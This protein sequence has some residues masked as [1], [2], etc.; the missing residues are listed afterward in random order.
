MS[1]NASQDEIKAAFRKLARQYH[2][3]INKDPGATDKFKEINEAY[4]VLGDPKKRQQFDTYG[5]VGNDLGGFNMNEINLEDLFQ[6]FA[7]GGGG[8]FGDVF[9]TFFGGGGGRR[10]QTGPQPGN[11]L[12][13]DMHLDLEEAFSGGEK[14]IEFE[15]FEKC[16]PCKGSGSE[17]GSG[18]KKCSSCNGTGQV[19]HATRT[20]FGSFQQ[21]APCAACAGRGEIVEKPCKTCRGTGRTRVKTKRKVEVPAGIDHGY[22]LRVGGAGDVGERGGRAGDLYVFI[23]VKP[24]KKFKRQ[25]NDLFVLEKVDFVSAILGDEITVPMFDGDIKVKVQPGTQPNTV[26]RVKGKGMPHLQSRSRGDLFVE[27]QV[28]IPTRLSKEQTELLK[29]IKGL[30]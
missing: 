25:G 14:E 13:Y 4:Q 9:E 26:I 15:H 8:A 29:K 5:S 12:R 22:R 16:S 11:D 21:I 27:V 19:R 10:Q 17:A 1:K 23:T 30:K 3:D 24:D 20:I 2:P 7:G 28:E 18:T 6:G